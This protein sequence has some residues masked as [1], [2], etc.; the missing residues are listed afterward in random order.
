MSLTCEAIHKPPTAKIQPRKYPAATEV[1]TG[2]GFR[3]ES[4][5]NRNSNRK[6]GLWMKL[7][8]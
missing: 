2:A 6:Q 5:H 3:P 1:L 7:R 8:S 4:S